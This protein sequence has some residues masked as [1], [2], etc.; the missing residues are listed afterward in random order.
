MYD[1]V[2]ELGDSR[3]QHGKSNDRVYLMKLGDRDPAGVLDRIDRLAEESGYSKLFAKVRVSRGPLL[4]QSG[5]RLEARIPGYFQGREDALFMSRFLSEERGIEGA[6]ERHQEVL[7]AACAKAGQGADGL[8]DGPYSFRPC[9]PEDAEEVA[10]VYRRVFETYP[11]PIHQAD[12]IHHTMA[13]HVRYYGVWCEG[14][15]VSLSSAEGDLA[16]GAAEMTD[17][18]TLPEHRR[19]GLGSFLLERMDRDAP[20]RGIHLGYTIARAVSFGMNITFAKLGYR[21]TGRLVNNTNI[22]GGME[23]MNVW[24]KP[25]AVPVGL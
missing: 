12:Y 24:Y 11:F 25:L 5:Y 2:E 3:I 20:D 7:T 13:T 15:L 8:P 19:K 1:R 18:A 10:G 14:E 17:F 9:R 4:E 21:Y 6:A 22:S 23:S 16:A